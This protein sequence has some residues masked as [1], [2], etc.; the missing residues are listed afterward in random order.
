MNTLAPII[1]VPSLDASGQ[2]IPLSPGL[3]ILAQSVLLAMEVDGNGLILTGQDFAQNADGTPNMAVPASGPAIRVRADANTFCF[4]AVKSALLSGFGFVVAQAFAD[5][6]PQAW[7]DAWDVLQT[8]AAATPADLAGALGAALNILEL[9][10]K[11]TQDASRR[12]AAF[13]AK[14]WAIPAS[15]IAGRLADAQAL[16]VAAQ[17]DLAALAEDATK[18]AKDA[19]ADE[20]AKLT[21]LVAERTAQARA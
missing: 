4:Q 20:V 5:P 14:H 17:A 15:V 8:K 19:A 13:A 16:L 3:P 12:A 7:F 11:P 2:Q 6:E 9:G 18:E 21:A 1:S 10:T